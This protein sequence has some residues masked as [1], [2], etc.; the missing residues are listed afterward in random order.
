MP[1]D[2]RWDDGGS[3]IF[4]SEL[5]TEAT[6]ILGAPLL[7]LEI[8]CD[9]PTAILAARLCDVSPSGEVTRVTYGLLNL[10]HRDGHQDLQPMEAGKSYCV[11][12]A[13]NEIGYTFPSGHRIRLSISTVYWP[14]A[15]PAPERARLTVRA[16]ASHV[17][18]P[19]RTPQPADSNLPVFKTPEASA[20]MA[21]TVLRPGSADRFIRIDL[22]PSVVSLTVKRDDGLV[23]LDPIGTVVGHEK[24]MIF[25]VAENDPSTVR[26]EVYERFEGG[27]GAWQTAVEGRTVLT[28]TKTD[29]HLQIDFNAIEN[30]DRI[31]CKSWSEKIS[32]DLV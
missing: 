31:F 29:F 24:H 8:T 22:V 12:L 13:M 25:S 28:A 11:R 19:I 23:R 17:H 14:I 9:K 15:L 5:M 4:D 32:R 3:L 18:L 27:R 26:T 10:S 7:E 20:P 30:G 6:P 21:T 16:E 1:L 2:Q